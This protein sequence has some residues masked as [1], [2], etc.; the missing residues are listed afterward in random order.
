MQ[1]DVEM[2]AGACHCGRLRYQTSG[3]PFAADYCHCKQCTRGAGAFAV[4]WMDFKAEQVQWEAA[5]PK[6]FTSSEKIRR[7]FC[8]HCG[9]S[10]SYRHLDHPGY[11]SLS[12]ATL[13][14]PE[15]VQPSYHIHTDSQVSWLR[16]DD[17]CKRYPRGQSD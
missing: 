1:T 10:L 8:E 9:S 14:D 3:R 7:G 2:L 13:D 16:I 5:E 6:E 11:Y 4:C 12:I 17:D 15:A